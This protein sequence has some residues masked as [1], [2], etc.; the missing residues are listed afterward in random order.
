[1]KTPIGFS[2]QTNENEEKQHNLDN[3]QENATAPSVITVSFVNGK[4]YPYYNDR[5]DLKVGDYVYVDGKLA[6]IRGRVISQTYQFCVNLKYYKR[7]LQKIDCTVHGT[8]TKSGMFLVCQDANTVP[9]SQIR[10]WFFPP[11]T[12][13]EKDEIVYGEGFQIN[14]SEKNNISA[15]SEYETYRDGV[16]HFYD[17]AVQYISCYHGNGV[18]IV[19]DD[20]APQSYVTV[21][22]HYAGGNMESIYCDCIEPS[23]CAHIPAVALTFRYLLDNHIIS[24]ENPDFCAL[25][26]EVFNRLVETQNGTIS[27]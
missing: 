24:E 13:D 23:Y 9:Y 21:S 1:M 26:E 8:F 5:F 15:N 3:P 11:E 22:F 16:E 14:L 20:S 2:M 18:A 27:V 19:E 12:E 10:P 7:V 4:Q 17:A 25:S 6:G